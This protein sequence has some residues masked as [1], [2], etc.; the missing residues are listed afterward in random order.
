MTKNE[1]VKLAIYENVNIPDEDKIPMI[2]LYEERTNN[3]DEKDKNANKVYLDAYKKAT[4]D[5]KKEI[6]KINT[7][8]SAGKYTEAKM[9]IVK[10]KKEL[11][12]VEKL[13]DETP[14]TLTDTALSQVPKMLVNALST[15]ALQSVIHKLFKEEK[16][17][18]ADKANAYVDKIDMY[19]DTKD[20]LK[21]QFTHALTDAPKLK[22]SITGE[23]KSAAFINSIDAL[24][25]KK[26]VQNN[27]DF[28][29]MAKRAIAKE[30][31]I[32]DKL[33]EKVSQ[34]SK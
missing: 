16:K 22:D 10:A 5:C 24:K 12:N 3:L 2:I 13:V 30:N 18:L 34:L 4:S 21:N 25:G 23:L 1:E 15:F 33:A 26:P 29:K 7:L 9:Q 11:Q 19:D 17:K 28:K 32:L 27:N 8:I 6:E 31:K 14:A 20:M